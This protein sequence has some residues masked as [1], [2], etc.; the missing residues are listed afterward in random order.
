MY[1]FRWYRFNAPTFEISMGKLF[2]LAQV[3]RLRR[4]HRLSSRACWHQA[5][6][7]APGSAPP[8]GEQSVRFLWFGI[9]TTQVGERA[10]ASGL[11][12]T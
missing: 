2:E 8:Q 3:V 11:V 4:G 7:P 9:G 12:E 5:A 10:S 6:R 1:I